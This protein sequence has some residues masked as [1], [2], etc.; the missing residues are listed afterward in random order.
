[1]RVILFYLVNHHELPFTLDS[2]LSVIIIGSAALGF[3][4]LNWILYKDQSHFVFLLIF[5]VKQDLLFD[6]MVDFES[7]ENPC[8]IIKSYLS[9]II[10]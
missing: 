6:F 10:T 1:M 4:L 5:Q 8:I 3:I 2:L 7:L 9:K